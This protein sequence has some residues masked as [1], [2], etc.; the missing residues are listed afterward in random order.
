MGLMIN[1]IWPVPIAD[2]MSAYLVRSWHLVNGGGGLND[3][4]GVH[5]V[6]RPFFPFLMAINQ[7]IGGEGIKSAYEVVWVVNALAAPIVFILTWK[8]VN[9][10]TA[11]IASVFVLT[12]YPIHHYGYRHL[13]LLW[14]LLLLMAFYFVLK[15]LKTTFPTK[16]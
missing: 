16:L 13:D 5:Q 10:D 12:A 8:M 11:W 2:D 6:A 1:W 9:S 15:A 14:P 7:W 4:Q 3:T